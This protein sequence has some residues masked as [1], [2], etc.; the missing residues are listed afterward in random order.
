MSSIDQDNADAVFA[1]SCFFNLYYLVDMTHPLSQHD[2]SKRENRHVEPPL[3]D[4]AYAMMMVPAAT[5][6]VKCCRQVVF[7]AATTSDFASAHLRSK[8]RQREV[9]NGE[10]MH[11]TWN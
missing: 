3:R 5:E 4:Q 2:A 7:I 8:G 11:S 1:M 6:L 9:M 10:D